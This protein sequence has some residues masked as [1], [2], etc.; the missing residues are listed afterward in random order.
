MRIA[1]GT[2]GNVSWAQHFE[3]EDMVIAGMTPQ[4]VVVAA[5]RNAADFLRLTDRGTIASGKVADLL[6]LDGNPL[7]DIKNT[8][9]IN[10]VYL[11]GAALNRSALPA[12]R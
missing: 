12:T 6:V 2:D 9:K 1:L 8:R 7:E 3:M 4:Q 11:S 5:T 10:A